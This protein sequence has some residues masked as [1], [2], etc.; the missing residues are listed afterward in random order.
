MA[1]IVNKQTGMPAD[2]GVKYLLIDC[3]WECK[4]VQ[5]L[6]AKVWRFLI[7]ST[8]T[9]PAAKLLLSHLTLINLKCPKL[10]KV[11]VSRKRRMSK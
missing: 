8:H 1:K 2:E 11:P 6:W 5:P 4:T 9:Y 3:Q 7:K 10:D